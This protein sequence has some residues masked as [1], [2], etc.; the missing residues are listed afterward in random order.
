VKPIAVKIRFRGV[1]RVLV[2]EHLSNRE[3]RLLAHELSLARI[4]VT[5]DSPPAPDDLALQNYL[6]ACSPQARKTSKEDWSAAKVEG[7]THGKAITVPE[8]LYKMTDQGCELEDGTIVEEPDPHDGRIV[9][10]EN[11]G[12][13]DEVREYGDEGYRQWYELFWPTFFVGQRVYV[14]RMGIGEIVEEDQNDEGYWVVI[15]GERVLVDA[16]DLNPYWGK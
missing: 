14:D 1:L 12:G 3:A 11:R 6:E 4:V 15:N 9:H 16:E 8:V 10:R 13:I 5:M 7:I 2:P